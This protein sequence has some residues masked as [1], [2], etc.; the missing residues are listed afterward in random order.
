MK[1]PKK[2][3]YDHECILYSEVWLAGEDYLIHSFGA[4]SICQY[5]NGQFTKATMMLVTTPCWWLYDGDS[6]M[7]HYGGDFSM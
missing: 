7:N 1:N 2:D 4:K 3:R 5:V 6:F